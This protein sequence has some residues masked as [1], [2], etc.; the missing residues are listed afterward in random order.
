MPTSPRLASTTWCPCA[1]ATSSSCSSRARSVPG[2]SYPTV[3]AAFFVESIF[4]VT[5]GVFVLV[6]AFTQGV[7]PK[8]PDFSKL[9]SFEI[10]YL[11]AHFR[12]T[13]FLIT[14]LAIAGL[15]AFALLSVRVKAFWARVRQG[16][17]ILND[18]P[19]LPAG[20]GRVAGRGVAL[21][22][23]RLLVPARRLPRRR[24]GTQR[25]ARLRGQPGRRRGPADPGRRRRAAGAARQGVCDERTDGRRGG[26][27]GRPAARDRYVHGARRP[28][29]RRVHL[30]LPL[31]WG[32]PA[33]RT[34]LARCRA[35]GWSRPPSR[36][37]AACTRAIPS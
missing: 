37:R 12:F 1:A 19:P 30:P 8:P 25:A 21:P 22:L 10:S 4:D 15:V 14:V 36:R 31:V 34:R 24:L 18:R 26:L 35:G 17:T 7:F 32:S 23:R 3:A 6:F 33:C 28:R 29:R 9:S 13:L 11:A 16:V 5:V 20:G 2:S 27:L